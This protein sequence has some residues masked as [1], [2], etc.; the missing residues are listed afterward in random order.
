MRVKDAM[1]RYNETAASTEEKH[2]WRT[3]KSGPRVNPTAVPVTERPLAAPPSVPEPNKKKVIFVCL[4]NACRSQ[5]AEAFAVKYGSDILEVASAGLTPASTLPDLTKA[6]MKD[7]G[8]SLDGHFSK[9]TEVYQKMH[10]DVVINMSGRP[11]GALTGD[12]MID[13]KIEDPMGQRQIVHERVRDE[14]EDLVM[15]LILEIRIQ[16][17][18]R[19]L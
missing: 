15:R 3:A 18:A 10:W 7:K 19:K 17:R 2:N 8:I 13:W 1:K 16:A 12:K 14:I 9:G 4:G 5:M 6:V 11:L